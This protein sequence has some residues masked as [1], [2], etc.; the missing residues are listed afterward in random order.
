MIYFWFNFYG[1]NIVLRHSNY[2]Y[3]I[4]NLWCQ[5]LWGGGHTSYIEASDWVER[6]HTREPI[7]YVFGKATFVSKYVIPM[8]LDG[9]PTISNDNSLNKFDFT[10]QSLGLHYF[11]L[12]TKAKYWRGLYPWSAQ[13]RARASKTKWD[14]LSAKAQTNELHA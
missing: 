7:I 8:I 11:I 6:H 3:R 1:N 12:I 2:S 9:P 14:L 13:L 4:I 5:F 10:R